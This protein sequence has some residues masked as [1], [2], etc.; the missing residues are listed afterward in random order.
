[1]VRQTQET[2]EAFDRQR[3]STGV[4]VVHEMDT[5][6]HVGE[7]G[8]REWERSPILSHRSFYLRC[9]KCKHLNEERTSFHHLSGQKS[10]SLG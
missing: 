6:S 1:M 9:K 3:E 2:L 5:V 7:A 4:P 8:V 10:L